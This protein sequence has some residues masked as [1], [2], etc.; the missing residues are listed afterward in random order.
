MISKKEMLITKEMLR[1]KKEKLAQE[2]EDISN[3]DLF[4]LCTANLLE[5]A[6]DRK[7]DEL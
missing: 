7:L 4:S 5:E 6:V 1:Q 3:E 2:G